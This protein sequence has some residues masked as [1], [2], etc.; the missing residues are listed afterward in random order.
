MKIDFQNGYKLSE[1]KNM[2]L[3]ALPPE[4][5]KRIFDLAYGNLVF[6]KTNNVLRKDNNPIYSLVQ[7]NSTL[8]SV[9]KIASICRFLAYKTAPDIRLLMKARFDIEMSLLPKPIIVQSPPPPPPRIPI[10]IPKIVIPKIPVETG[11]DK[12]RSDELMKLLKENALATE[13]KIL[14]IEIE[15]PEPKPF[16]LD[17][18]VPTIDFKEFLKQSPLEKESGWFSTLLSYTGLT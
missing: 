4:V 17:I 5:W 9:A 13:V 14:P 6:D 1:E 18:T 10:K 8:A 2:H 16:K 11:M 15:L 3:L 12:I 7:C